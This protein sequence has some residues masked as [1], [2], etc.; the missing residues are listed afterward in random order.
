MEDW[1][2]LDWEYSQ[3]FGTGEFLIFCF[4]ASTS[5]CSVNRENT[6]TEES[7]VPDGTV[8]NLIN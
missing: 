1:P 2:L 6:C 7:T 3:Y 8:V 5:G 4:N